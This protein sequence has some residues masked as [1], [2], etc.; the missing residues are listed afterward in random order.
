[1]ER[2]LA[3]RSLIALVV[4]GVLST[5]HASAQVT[6]LGDWSDFGTQFQLGGSHTRQV[7]GQPVEWVGGS[8]ANHWRMVQEKGLDRLVVAQDPTSPKGGAVL[9]VQILPG[10]NVGWTGERAEVSYMMGIGGKHIGVTLDSGHEVYGI[11]V[12]LDP[13]WVPP[14]HDATHGNTWGIFLQ[15]H[16]PDPFHSPPAFQLAVTTQFNAGLLGG[17]LIDANGHRRDVNSYTLTKGE[18]RTGHWVEFMVDVVWA[19]DNTGSLTVYR[20]DEGDTLFVPVFTQTRVPT[21][22]FDSQLP[23]SQNTDPA[24]NATTYMHYW[25]MG[26]YRSVSPGVTS[27]LSLGPVVRGTSLQEVQAAAFGPTMSPNPPGTPV[28]SH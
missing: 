24:Q 22:Q 12:K 3:L 18:L 21:L 10:D 13:N 23:N 28:V 19:Y 25:K 6:F 27:R 16:S 11:S 14:L 15:L 26:Y 2:R 8:G 7:N 1:M 4:F 17:N 20:K 5:A 9:Q